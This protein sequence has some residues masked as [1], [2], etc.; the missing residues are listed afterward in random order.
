MLFVSMLMKF[1]LSKKIVEKYS[2]I[3]FHEKP[4]IGSRAV[5]SAPP[6]GRTDRQTNRRDEA[7]SRFS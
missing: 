4:S 7:N 2:N 5:P 6:A 3:K 1:E